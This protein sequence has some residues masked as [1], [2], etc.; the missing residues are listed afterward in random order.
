MLNLRYLRTFVAI[1]DYGSFAIAADRLGLTQSAVSMQMKSLEDNL[2]ATIFDRSRRS[3]KLNDLGKSLLETAREIILLGDNLRQVA[4][5]TEDLAGT[6]RL[7]VITSVSSG[8]LPSAVARLGDKHPSFNIRI[9]N[10]HSDDLIQR[11]RDGTIDAAVVTE[12]VPSGGN[13]SCRTIVEEPLLVVTPRACDISHGEK[14]L[15]ELPFIRVNRSTGIGRIINTCLRQMRIRVQ[16]SMELDSIESILEMVAEGNGVA[17]VP[18]HCMTVRY[19]DKLR[20]L[21]FGNPPVTRKV[22]F[23]ER[24]QHPRT[25]FTNALYEQL[26]VSES[27]REQPLSTAI[28]KNTHAKQS[29]LVADR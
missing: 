19:I 15:R 24:T 21:P 14:V 9:E 22:G 23:V 12:P 1:D 26:L 27:E 10:G 16:E 6:I 13:L 2:R 8:A 7:G 20:A 28:A 17:V 3:P 5:S 29:V 11:V 25:A 4:S 18:E